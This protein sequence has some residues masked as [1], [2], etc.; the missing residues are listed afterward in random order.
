MK[1][2]NVRLPYKS[3]RDSAMCGTAAPSQQETFRPTLTRL[4]QVA[5]HA[6]LAKFNPICER[7]HREIPPLTFR[8]PFVIDGFD[9]VLPAGAYKL[10]SEQQ[11]LDGRFLPDSLRSSV[12]IHLHAKLGSPALAQTLTVPWDVL[13]TALSCDQLPAEMPAD[14]DLD[15]MMLE[16]IVRLV[17][18]R[19]GVS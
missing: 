8:R 3:G 5:A 12:L 1:T 15:Q 19:D 13:E 18:S 17:M 9:G 10:E 6:V 4:L 7:R 16:P 14:L 2:Q 11:I